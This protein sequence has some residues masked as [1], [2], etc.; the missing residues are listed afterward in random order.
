MDKK[1]YLREWNKMHRCEK[2]SIISEE[3]CIK[4]YELGYREAVLLP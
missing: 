1:L 2:E 3:S 4:R